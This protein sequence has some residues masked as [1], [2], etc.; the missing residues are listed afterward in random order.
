MANMFY[1]RCSLEATV[2]SCRT[3]A[4]ERILATAS[5]SNAR[6]RNSDLQ[7]RPDELYAGPGASPPSCLT[8][9]QTRHTLNVIKQNY[10]LE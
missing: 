6:V 4:L 1:P 7:E 2:S 3:S 9:K 10:R 5:N 8:H